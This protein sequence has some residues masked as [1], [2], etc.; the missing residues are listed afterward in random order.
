MNLAKY[1]VCLTTRWAFMVLYY[2]TRE[3]I[4]ESLLLNLLRN[5]HL[6]SSL[7]FSCL[8]KHLVLFV[9]SEASLLNYYLL[10]SVCVAFLGVS[11]SLNPVLR[12]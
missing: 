5:L 4:E 12:Y 3:E 8:V 2:W 9:D 11:F 7:D 6:S 10:V 1:T